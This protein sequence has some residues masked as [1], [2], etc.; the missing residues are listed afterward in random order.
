MMRY[1][2][3]VSFELD[4]TRIF[5]VDSEYERCVDE[6]DFVKSVQKVYSGL[7]QLIKESKLGVD[8][9]IWRPFVDDIRES[10]YRKCC[11]CDDK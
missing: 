1:I 11:K 7:S 5:T 9:S 10:T 2:K 8:E 6:Y 3:L 4:G